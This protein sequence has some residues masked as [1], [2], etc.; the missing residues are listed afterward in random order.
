MPR[1]EQR[2]NREKKKPKKDKGA[3]HV[4]AYAAQYGKQQPSHVT[5]TASG[6]KQ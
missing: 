6:K 2:G 1:G 4:S 5:D 3:R